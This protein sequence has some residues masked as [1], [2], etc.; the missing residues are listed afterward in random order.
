M[1]ELEY[2]PYREVLVK[3]SVLFLALFGLI[4]RAEAQVQTLL[5]E[6]QG[7]AFKA[8][9]RGQLKLDNNGN[10]SIELRYKSDLELCHVGGGAA[11]I[12]VFAVFKVGEGAA[13]VSYSYPMTANC[14][15]T[16]NVGSFYEVNSAVLTFN[17]QQGFVTDLPRWSD[18]QIWGT[19]FPADAQ[20]R[21]SY[22][23][24]MTFEVGERSAGSVDN[25]LGRDYRLVFDV[26][27]SRQ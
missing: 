14:P 4:G 15:W 26:Q 27:P 12:E 11:P 19:L 21:R 18:S 16:P 20:G 25:K 22:A 7:G 23:L 6:D 8:T 17:S 13:A 5:A 9:V 10:G 24:K 2:A 3:A 1:W